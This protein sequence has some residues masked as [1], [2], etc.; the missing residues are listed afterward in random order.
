M[1]W[2]ANITNA[3]SYH[4]EMTYSASDGAAGGD[5]GI[6]VGAQKLS[7]KPVST[8]GWMD[9]ETIDAGVVKIEQPG[10]QPF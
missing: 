10:G 7:V 3:G 1:E 8:E 6:S 2:Q 9:Y 4:V 5:L